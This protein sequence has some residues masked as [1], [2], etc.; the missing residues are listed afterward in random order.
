M[1]K[2]Y[3]YEYDAV[4]NENLWKTTRAKTAD[5]S[6]WGALCLRSGRDALKAVAR[7]LGTPVT[8]LMPALSCASMTLPFTLYGH[9]VVYYK[10]TAQYTIDLQALTDKIP[11][12]KAVF[13]YMDYFGIPALRDRDLEYL[14]KSYPSL[15]FVEDRTHTLLWPASR[16]FSAD[17]TVASLRKWLAIP[18]G[19]LLWTK[20]PLKDN[21]FGED[22]AFSE[23]RLQAQ[24]LRHR[25]FAEGD[26]EIKASY[27]RIFSGVSDIL[28]ANPL[29]SRMTRYAYESAAAADWDSI[30]QQRK[31]NAQTLIAVLKKGGIQLIQEQPGWSDLYVA[32]QTENRENKQAALS[33]K[34]I[35]NTVIWPLS[36]VQREVCPIARQTEATMLAAPCDQRYTAQDMEYIGNEIVRVVN[37]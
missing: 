23:K 5:K 7:E 4:L 13:L 27:R 17:F 28:D 6:L 15:L 18:D 35:F 2:E 16:T 29:P 21:T 32:F 22:H 31:I 11:S 9:R 25:F 30:R 8:V 36:D 14:R 1:V 24:C 26:P 33:A 10:L 3:G 19:G 37:E 34:A 12:E 20:T